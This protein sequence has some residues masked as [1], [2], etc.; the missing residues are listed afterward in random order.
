MHDI[1]LAWHGI[2]TLIII[3]MNNFRDYKAVTYYYLKGV[4]SIFKI[5][6]D[7]QAVGY[8]TDIT[9]RNYLHDTIQN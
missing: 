4:K 3:F 6:S 5:R 1:P 9:Y 2:D 7:E 8:G